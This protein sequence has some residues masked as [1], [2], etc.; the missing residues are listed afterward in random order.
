MQGQRCVPI[1]LFVLI[2][3]Y[4]KLIDVGLAKI[5]EDK[6]FVYI[7]GSSSHHKWLT[8]LNENAKAGGRA[9]ARC[10]T[11]NDRGFFQPSSSGIQRSSSSSSSSS[12]KRKNTSSFGNEG[13]PDWFEKIYQGYPRKQGK[14]KGFAKAKKLTEEERNQLETAIAHYA[15]SKDVQDGYVK[16]FDTFMGEWRDWLDPSTGTVYRPAPVRWVG[17][18]D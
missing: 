1:T 6:D 17:N 15:R 3:E 13:Y 8:E 7:C 10:A 2:P 14:S 5:A 16:H 9:R 18:L 11:R 4:Q 12:K